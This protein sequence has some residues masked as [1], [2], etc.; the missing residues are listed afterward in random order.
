MAPPYNNNDTRK[1]DIVVA[2]HL[3]EPNTNEGCTQSKKKNFTKIFFSESPTSVLEDIGNVRSQK[4]NKQDALPNRTECP[5]A[6]KEQLLQQ[7]KWQHRLSNHKHIQRQ[8]SSRCSPEQNWRSKSTSNTDN[9]PNSKRGA[10][11]NDETHTP[12]RSQSWD[13]R[14]ERGHYSTR[15]NHLENR[16]RQAIVQKNNLTKHHRNRLQGGSHTKITKY[17]FNFYFCQKKRM[18]GTKI[19][20]ITGTMYKIACTSRRTGYKEQTRD[21]WYHKK[22]DKQS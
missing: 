5:K 13:D 22:S 3:D 21:W 20:S 16:R 7:R 12:T 18:V 9:R 11:N 4:S 15:G 6:R 8:N 19:G 17:E 1:L 2:I 14:S 10:I